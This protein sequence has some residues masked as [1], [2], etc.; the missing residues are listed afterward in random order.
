MASI[1]SPTGGGSRIDFLQAELD[2]PARGLERGVDFVA[3]VAPAD[4]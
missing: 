3:G 1:R 4:L 2:R